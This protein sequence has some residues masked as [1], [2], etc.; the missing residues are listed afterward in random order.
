MSDSSALRLTQFFL[1]SS[2]AFL[3]FFLSFCFFFF[4]Q[5]QKLS[6]LY[7]MID[8]VTNA[9][10]WILT[11]GAV[12]KSWTGKYAFGWSCWRG[13]VKKLLHDFSDLGSSCNLR[14]FFVN[15]VYK[16]QQVQLCFLVW[17]FFKIFG[18]VCI[19]AGYS[20]GSCYLLSNCNHQ[21]KS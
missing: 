14:I 21:W 9:W 8:C 19:D 17:I 5:Q 1:L 16:F 6:T 4:L 18:W 15:L 3:I 2:M 10:Q 7:S 12:I 11:L 13:S 20:E